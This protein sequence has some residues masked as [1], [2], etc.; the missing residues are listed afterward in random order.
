MRPFLTG[1]PAVPFLAAVLLLCRTTLAQVVIDNFDRN[2]PLLSQ[3]AV[4]NTSSAVTGSMLGGERDQKVTVTTTGEITAE[5]KNGTYI[6]TQAAGA[7]GNAEIVWDGTDGN[8]ATINP[9]G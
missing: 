9:T 5:V 1:L 6:F 7:V 4:G 3:T 8:G 2:Q